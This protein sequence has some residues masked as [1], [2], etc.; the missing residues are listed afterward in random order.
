[1][2]VINRHHVSRMPKRYKRTGGK[3]RRKS[4]FRKRRRTY[5][6]VP[7]GHL[8]LK[9]DYSCRLQSLESTFQNDTIA[10]TRI[11][12]QFSMNTAVDF[13]LF[14]AIFDQY[15]IT[16]VVVHFVPVKTEVVTRPYDDTTTP[17]ANGDTPMLAYVIDRDDATTGGDG[18]DEIRNR[19]GVI[20]KKMTSPHSVTFTPSRL[21]S[22]YQS[23]TTTGYVIDTDKYAWLDCATN[24]I[25]HYGLKIMGQTA[26][27]AG[28]FRMR[29][30]T[31][32][33]LQFRSRRH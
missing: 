9:A 17:N 5:A 20:I 2:Y 10:D 16:K 27:P 19:Q 1:M 26:S 3:R 21:R 13:G 18:F 33:H 32:Y 11:G 12:L 23:P 28:A 15:R 22:V 31:T 29:Y 25:P 8:R 7:R 24:S 14:T 4:T 6:R 30:W